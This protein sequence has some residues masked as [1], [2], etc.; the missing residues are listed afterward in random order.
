MNAPR[1]AA[2]ALIALLGRTSQAA[3]VEYKI[4]EHALTA[5]GHPNQQLFLRSAGFRMTLDALG[6]AATHPPVW[7]GQF[8]MWGG[9]P[10]GFPPPGEIRGLRFDTKN[11]LVWEPEWSGGGYHV[12]RSTM[13]DGSGESGCLW[14]GL[15][16]ETAAADGAIRLVEGTRWFYLV[17]AT[18]R[19]GEQGTLGIRSDGAERSFGPACP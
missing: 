19:L 13:S 7:N 11:T 12:Y 5:A 9:F 2:V 18:N 8:E 4:E 10:G 6:E 1:A 15:K 14:S 17:A 3:E 16:E